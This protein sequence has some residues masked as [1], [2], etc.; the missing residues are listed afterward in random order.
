M[1]NNMLKRLSVPCSLLFLLIFNS[2]IGLSMDIQMRKDGSGKISMEYRVSKK[3]EAIGKFDGNE[4]WP[5]VPVGRADFERSIARIPDIRIASFS[6]SERQPDVITDVTLEFDNPQALLKFLDPSGTKA[7]YNEG[8]LDITLLEADLKYDTDLLDLVRQVSAGYSFTVSFS[9]DSNSTMTITDGTGKEIK[10]PADSQFV[11]SGKKV[12]W[13]T[14][15]SEIFNFTN[16][17]VV[18]FNW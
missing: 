13:S 18:N 16:G 4:N 14:R 8:R 2:C 6:S 3:A 1:K 17:L 5:I 9:A 7:H 15:I 10:P 12:S 11:Q